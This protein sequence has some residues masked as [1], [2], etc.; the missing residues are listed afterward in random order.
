MRTRKSR[1]RIAQFRSQQDVSR[2]KKLGPESLEPRLLLFASTIHQNLTADALGF[3]Q[4]EV[5]ADIN[6]EH[7]QQD[8]LGQFNQAN[9]FDGSHFSDAANNI[10]AWYMEALRYADPD[11]FRQE[12]AADSFGKVLHAVQDFYSHSNW[13]ELQEAGR[14][15]RGTLIDTGSGYFSNLAPYSIHHGAMIVQGEDETPFGPSSSLSLDGFVV[16]VDT[17][18]GVYPG[19]ISG[20][21]LLPDQTPDNVTVPHGGLASLGIDGLPLAKDD[22]DALLF[23]PAKE[24]AV[25]QT[26]H[27]LFRL[28][29]LVESEYGSSQHLISSWIAPD[30][31]SDFNEFVAL[32]ASHSVGMEQLR[33]QIDTGLISGV[34]VVTHG[35]QFSDTG[36]DSLMPLAQAVLQRADGG[37]L[38]DYDILEEGAQPIVQIENLSSGPGNEVVVL[39]DWAPESNETSAG[40]GEAAGDALFANLIELGLLDLSNAATSHLPLHFV[41]HSFGTAVTSEA[42]ERLARF[43][44]EVD[45]VTLLDPHEFNQFILPVDGAQSLF[46]LGQ[47]QGYGATIWENVEFADVYYQTKTPPDGRPIPGAYN[48]YLPNDSFTDCLLPHSC[49]WQSDY[50]DSIRATGISDR[51]GYSRVAGGQPTRPE[52][53]FF[54]APP[55]QSHQHSEPTIVHRKTGEP[56]FEDLA[57]LGFGDELTARDNLTN[58]RWEPQWNSLSVINGDFQDAGVFHDGT[59]DP[60]SDIVPGWSHHGGGGRG[61]IGKD[62]ENFFLQLDPGNSRRMHNA[63]F[64]PPY[65]STLSFDL[66]RKERSSNNNVLEIRLGDDSIGTFPLGL[67]VGNGFVSTSVEIPSHLRNVNSLTFEIV[68]NGRIVDSEVRIDN[69]RLERGGNTGDVIEVNLRDIVPGGEEYALVPDAFHIVQP[70]GEIAVSW[71]PNPLRGDLL[72]YVGNENNVIGEVVFSDRADS[73][74]LPFS[75]S[76]RFYLAPGTD[77]QLPGD[78]D[79]DSRGWQGDLKVKFEV[80]GQ[81]FSTILSIIDGISQGGP[82]AVDPADNSVLNVMRLQQRLGYLGFPDRNGER[83]KVD[84][85]IGDETQHA[86][87]LFNGAVGTD[88]LSASDHLSDAGIQFINS[89]EAPTWSELPRQN[90]NYTV[91]T[92][93]RYGTSWLTETV[94]LA[95]EAFMR[96]SGQQVQIHRTSG[97]SGGSPDDLHD[98]FGGMGIDLIVT[99][100]EINQRIQLVREF[101]DYARGG[102]SLT[103]IALADDAQAAAIGAEFPD[104]DTVVDSR[105]AMDGRA[106]MHLQYTPPYPGQ[107]G[108]LDKGEQE[109]LREGVLRAGQ[110]LAHM[111]TTAGFAKPLPLVGETGTLPASA[112]ADAQI[113]IGQSLDLSNLMQNQ[114]ADSM[115]DVLS[116]GQSVDTVASLLQEEL[117]RLGPSTVRGTSNSQELRF[118]VA[119]D[120]AESAIQRDLTLGT[121]ARGLG[122]QIIDEVSERIPTVDIQPTLRFEFSFGLDRDSDVRD[123]FFFEVHALN[124][125]VATIPENDEQEFAERE[126]DLK[127][128][129]V[130]FDARIRFKMSAS[131]ELSESITLHQLERGEF[132]FATDS[133]F[134]ANADLAVRFGDFERRFEDALSI[135]DANLFDNG[136]SAANLS[137]ESLTAGLSALGSLTR[138]GFVGILQQFGGFF[139]RLGTSQ[140]FSAPLPFTNDGNV[141]NVVAP[142]NAWQSKVIDLLAQD[143]TS[144]SLQKLMEKA[145]EAGIVRNYRL[146]D[147]GQFT[148]DVNFT[149]DFDAQP[150][151]ILLD[152]ELFRDL[153]IESTSTLDVSGTLGTQLT[154]GID[155]S[156][157]G[158]GFELIETM[159]LDLLNGG[160]GIKRLDTPAA[161]F[162]VNFRDGTEL[163]IDVDH[164][165]DAGPPTVAEFRDYINGLSP[166]KLMLRIAGDHFELVDTSGGDAVFTIT[167][168]GMGTGERIS[169]AAWPGVGLGI[170]GTAETPNSRGEYVILGSALHGDSLGNRFYIATDV[171]TSPNILVSVSAISNDID[172]QAEYKKA[173]EVEI[174]N[175]A[176]S[177]GATLNIPLIDPD[178]EPQTERKLT[179]SELLQGLNDPAVHIVEPPTLGLAAS[180][181][182]PIKGSLLNVTIPGTARVDYSWQDTFQLTGRLN[183]PNPLELRE[184]RRSIAERELGPLAWLSDSSGIN[185]GGLANGVTQLFS[186]ES[187]RTA[188]PGIKRKLGDLLN[189]EGI[190][191]KLQESLA[192]AS[193]KAIQKVASV[194]EEEIEN[195]LCED[196]RPECTV[197][198]QGSVTD[199]QSDE[200]ALKFEVILR[201]EFLEQRVPLNLDL[202]ELGHG[203]LFAAGGTGAIDIE[204]GYDL[205]LDFGF[206][207]RDF[208]PFLYNSS[209]ITASMRVDSNDLAFQTSIGPLG[210]F[211]GQ[212]EPGGLKGTVQLGALKN[213]PRSL[214]SSN[215]RVTINDT[216]GDNRYFLGDEL[217]FSVDADGF[218]DI[219]LPIFFPTVSENQLDLN[220]R[221]EDL[222]DLTDITFSPS[223]E[224]FEMWFNDVLGDLG[225]LADNFRAIVTGWDGVFQILTDALDG[226]VFG[227]TIPFIGDKLQANSFIRELRRSVGDEFADVPPGTLT[228]AAVRNVL[229]NTLGKSEQGEGASLLQELDGVPGIT[230]QDIWIY[231]DGMRI[232]DVADDPIVVPQG[233]EE[234]W[235]EMSLGTTTSIVDSTFDFDIGLGDNFGLSL[236]NDLTV[237]ADFQIERFGIGV[238]RNGVFLKQPRDEDKQPLPIELS[239]TVDASL[240]NAT[241]DGRF[242]PF[243]IDGETFDQNLDLPCVE[244]DPFRKTCLHATFEVELDDG[245]D[246]TF[247]FDE[248]A[249]ITQFIEADVSGEAV[250][251]LNLELSIGGDESLP[252]LSSA[253]HFDWAFANE[254]TTGDNSFGEMPNVEF[255]NVTLDFG[256]F[257]RRF[258]GPI[259]T[260]VD[261]FLSPLDPIIDVLETPLPIIS[262]LGGSDVTPLELAQLLADEDDDGFIN[263]AIRVIEIVVG[264]RELV[265]RL[266]GFGDDVEISF[267][268]YP[269]IGDLRHESIAETTSNHEANPDVFIPADEKAEIDN[270]VCVGPGETQDEQFCFSFPILEKRSQV[271]S[272]LTGGFQ[273]S[274]IDLFLLDMPEL[275]L[276]FDLSKPPFGFLSPPFPV[277]PPFLFAYI[278]GA[279]SVAADF[280]FG[281]DTRGIVAFLENGNVGDIF[282]DGFYLLDRPKGGPDKPELQFGGTVNVTIE[283]PR[284]PDFFSFGGLSF[285]AGVGGGLFATIDLDLNDPN[286]DD[287]VYLDEL[288]DN[289]DRGFECVFDVHGDLSAQLFAFLNVK[290]KLWRKSVTLMDWRKEFV[291]ETLIDFNHSC[292]QEDSVP[293]ENNVLADQS[294]NTLTLRL[295]GESGDRFDI[296][297]R[298]DDIF[299]TAGGTTSDPYS[300][301]TKIVW[302]AGGGNDVLVVDRTVRSSVTIEVHGGS[303]DDRMVAYGGHARFYGDAGTDTLVGGPYD[304]ELHGGSEDDLLQGNGGVDVLYGEAGDDDLQGGSGDDR[305][306]GGIG[307]DRLLGGSGADSLYGED[308][309]DWLDGGD[310][311]DVLGRARD[312]GE[313]DDDIVLDGGPGNDTI[314][315]NEGNDVQIIG[316]PGEDQIDG[317]RGDDWIYGN[318]GNDRLDGGAGRDHVYGGPGEDIIHGGTGQ[319]DLFG[320]EDADFI[321]AGVSIDGGDLDVLNKI[322]GGDGRDTIYGDSGRDEVDGGQGDDE[323]FGLGGDDT[324]AGGDGNDV[325]FGGDGGDKITGGW[326]AD[327]IYAGTDAT[328]DGHVNEIHTIHGDVED[329]TT[330]VP[331]GNHDDF[332]R[333]A[334]GQDII[335]GFAG[336]DRIFAGE[337]GTAAAEQYIDAGEGNNQVSS[338]SGVDRILAGFGNDI[339]NAGGGA[340]RI[341]IAGG[342]NVIDAGDGIDIVRT[343]LG[344]D[345]I[346]VQNGDNDIR[347]TGGNN[348]VIT[349]NGSDIIRT[350][351]GVDRVES[352]AGDDDID[353]GGG[354]DT[355]YSGIGSDRIVGGWG[356]DL[357]VSGYSQAGGGPTTDTNTIFGDAESTTDLPPLSRQEDHAD[358]IY[359]DEGIDRVFAGF[360][361]DRIET[362]AGHDIVSA[363]NGNDHLIGGDGNDLLI[364]G[365]GDDRLFG[366]SGADIL[367]GGVPESAVHLLPVGV[368]WSSDATSDFSWLEEFEHLT[369]PFGFEDAELKASEFFGPRAWERSTHQNVT[370]T[371]LKVSFTIDGKNTSGDVVGDGRDRMFG[372]SDND[373]LFGGGDADLLEGGTGHDYLDGGAA[374]DTLRGDD[375]DDV[376]RGGKNNDVLRGGIGIDQ[377]YG[378]EGDDLLFADAG[379]SGIQVGQRLWGGAG[380]DTLYAYAAYEDEDSDDLGDLDSLLPPHVGDHL[381]GQAGEDLLFGNF[382]S[383]LLEGGGESDYLHGDYLGGPLYAR[384]TDAGISGL[385]DILFGGGGQDQLFGGGGAD[386]LH[387]EEDGD[388]LEGMDGADILVGGPGIDLLA[389]DVDSRYQQL[390]GDS[391]HGHWATYNTS[392][393]RWEDTSVAGDLWDDILVLQGDAT[394]DTNGQ[395]LFDDDISVIESDVGGAL[396]VSYDS[397]ASRDET[398]QLINSISRS[399][400]L[401]TWSPTVEQIQLAGLTGDDHLSVVLTKDT[402]ERLE[403]K[404]DQLHDV[405]TTKWVTTIGGGSGD[406]VLYGTAGRDRMDGGPGSDKLYGNAG[407]DRLWG[408]YFNGDPQRDFDEL[409]AGQGN[410]D[411]IGGSG[412][413]VLSAWS[414]EPAARGQFGIFVDST[415]GLH[416]DDDGGVYE[417]E[418]TGLNRM[419]G[420]AGPQ[421]DHLYGGTGLDFLYGNGGGGVNGDVLYTRTGQRFEE[422]GNNPFGDETDSTDAWKAYARQTDAVW[423]IGDVLDKQ[424]GKVN[425]EGELLAGFSDA[426]EIAEVHFITDPNSRTGGRHRVTIEQDGFVTDVYQWDGLSPLSANNQDLIEPIDLFIDAEGIALTLDPAT[427]RLVRRS[428]SQMRS[429]WNVTETQIVGTVLP[430]EG[431]FD[432]IL[433][434]TLGGNDFVRV[435][436]TVQKTV[437]V[438]AGDGDDVVRIDPRLAFLPDK[439]DSISHRNDI[440]QDVAARPAEDGVRV[441]GNATLSGLTIDSPT[442]VDWYR[443]SLD[444]LPER[445]DTF[446][447]RRITRKADEANLE[448]YIYDERILADPDTP[449]IGNGNVAAEIEL[450]TGAFNIGDSYFI[451]VESENGVTTDYEL[452]WT[453][454]SIPDELESG[455][456]PNTSE[457][458]PY[459]IAANEYDSHLQN[460]TLPSPER[461]AQGDWFQLPAGVTHGQITLHSLSPSANVTLELMLNSGTVEAAVTVPADSETGSEILAFTGLP[462]APHLLRVRADRIARYGLTLD[463]S[464]ALAGVGSQDEPWLMGDIHQFRSYSNDVQLGTAPDGGSE[465][466][467]WFTFFL[468][469]PAKLGTGIG[470][471]SLLVSDTDDST[472]NLFDIQLYDHTGSRMLVEE[473]T[474]SQDPLVILDLNGLAPGTYRVRVAGHW[475]WDESQQ[476][477]VPQYSN[478]AAFELFSATAHSGK[479]SIDFRPG[480]LTNLGAPVEERR[481]VVL[482]GNGD[483]R[484]LGGSGEDWIF[485]GEG[486]DILSGGYD[487]QAEDLIIG[488]DGDDIFFLTPDFLANNEDVGNSDIFVG[489]TGFDQVYYVGGHE[490]DGGDDQPVGVRDFVALGFDRFLGRHKITSLIWNTEEGSEGFLQTDQGFAQQYAFFRANEVERT[491]VDTRGGD[492]IVHADSGYVLN[493]ETWGISAGDLAAGASAFSQ[494]SILGGDGIDVLL[495]GAG[496]EVIVGESGD[497]ADASTNY[498]AG[499]GG[500]DVLLGGE[501]R[502]WIYGGRL[503]LDDVNLDA[504]MIATNALSGTPDDPSAVGSSQGKLTQFDFVATIYNEDAQVRLEYTFQ[505]FQGNS[506]I[507]LPGDVSETVTLENSFVLESVSSLDQLARLD[508][509]GDLNADGLE[510]YLVA[511]SSG[512]SYILFGPVTESSLTRVE[513]FLWDGDRKNGIRI[514]GSTWSLERRFDRLTDW[515]ALSPFVRVEGRSEVIVSPSIG[516]AAGSGQIL[517]S[518]NLQNPEASDL[519]LIRDVGAQLE[520]NIVAG[521]QTLPRILENRSRTILI[522]KDGFASSVDDIQIQILDWTGDDSGGDGLDEIIVL[523]QPKAP[524]AGEAVDAERVVGYV[525]DGRTLT[526]A[527]VDLSQ[528]DALLTIT[529]DTTNRDIALKQLISPSWTAAKTSSRV[530]GAAAGDINRDGFED[531]IVGDA[532]YAVRDSGT[533]TDAI[534][535]V[536][537]I[538]GRPR[539]AV[540]ETQAIL[541]GGPSSVG[542]TEPYAGLAN[543]VW[544]G[545]GLGS[546]VATVGD[547][548]RDGYD[549]IAF[550]REFELTT[551]GSVFIIGGD[552]RFDH[553]PTASN[554]VSFPDPNDNSEQS[555]HH[556]LARIDRGVNDIVNLD[557]TAGDFDGNGLVDIVVANANDNDVRIYYDIADR[558]PEARLPIRTYEAHDGQILGESENDGFGRLSMTPSLDLN[559]DGISD[560]VVGA[561]YADVGTARMNPDVDAGKV[562]IIFGSGRSLQLPDTR[563]ESTL[564][565]RQIPGGGLF[566]VERPDGQPF[567]LQH[568]ELTSFDTFHLFRVPIDTA[569]EQLLDAGEVSTALRNA[570]AN[571]DKPLPVAPTVF[572]IRP[573][574]E[575]QIVA[576]KNR[577]IVVKEDQ[578]VDVYDSKVEQWFTFT[579]LGD[580]QIGDVIKL[581]TVTESTE[582]ISRPENRRTYSTSR[583]AVLDS[584]PQNDSVAIE[585][586][587]LPLQIAEHRDGTG[588]LSSPEANVWLLG[589]SSTNSQLILE[590]DLSRLLDFVESPHLLESAQIILPYSHP[591]P[592]GGTVQVELLDS[593]GDGVAKADDVVAPAER[594]RHSP[595]Q[596]STQPKLAGE[597]SGTITLDVTREVQDALAAGRTRFT[598]RVS[599]DVATPLRISEDDIRIDVQTGRRTGVVAELFDSDG[600]RLAGGPTA[601]SII[602]LRNLRAGQYH[603]RVFD[604]LV[605]PSNVLYDPS[606]VPAKERDDLGSVCTDLVID[607]GPLSFLVEI[608]APKVGDADPVSDRDDI[609]GA[610]GDDFLEGGP[611]YDRLFGERNSE[612]GDRF[613]GESVEVRDQD[614]GA[615][616]GIVCTDPPNLPGECIDSNITGDEGYLVARPDDFVVQIGDTHLQSAIALELGLAVQGPDQLFRPIR[617]LLATDMTRLVQ[618]DADRTSLSQLARNDHMLTSIDGVEYAINLEYVSFA[619]Q[620]IQNL[621]QVEPGIRL[622]R[623]DQGELGL[624]SLR[625]VDLD[626]NPLTNG[627]NQAHPPQLVGPLDAISRLANLE[628][629]SI[630]RLTGDVQGF[631]LYGFEFAEELRNLRWLSA[632]ANQITDDLSLRMSFTEVQNGDVLDQSG[633]GNHGSIIG[634][635]IVNEAPPHVSQ[636]RSLK[637]NG[638]NSYVEV[639]NSP[640]LNVDGDVTISVWSKVDSFS[641]EWMPL[642]YKGNPGSERTYSI[643]IRNTGEVFL[644]TSD[645]KLNEHVSTPANSVSPNEWHHIAGS[646]DRTSGEMRIYL[647]G[648]LE[649]TKQ[650]RIQEAAASREPL[651]IGT[652]NES[653]AGNADY[654]GNVSDLQIYRAV[655][656]SFEIGQVMAG[657]AL[658]SGLSPLAS[659]A[660]L[661]VLNADTN[662]LEFVSPITSLN[663]L[664]WLELQ[665]NRLGEIV[666]LIGQDIVDDRD[667]GYSEIGAGWTADAHPD[668]FG[669]DYRILP[670]WEQ[671]SKAVFDFSDLPPGT[672]EIFATWPEHASRTDRASY[673]F[674]ENDQT[675]EVNQ[676]FAPDGHQFAG[677]SWQSVGLVEST[678]SG[679]TVELTNLGNGNLAADSVRVVSSVLPSLQMANL[680]RN[681]LDNI[682]H[683]LVLPALRQP[684][685][686]GPIR[687]NGRDSAES[688]IAYLFDGNDYV[689]VRD[690]T[691]LQMHDQVTIEAWIYPTGPGNGAGIILNKEGEYEIFRSSDGHIYWVIANQSHGWFAGVNT[692][693]VA[694]ENQWT[695]IAFTYDGEVAKTYANGD[696]VDSR[697]A[698]GLIGDQYP[699]QNELRIGGRQRGGDFF[700]GYIDDVQVW[701]V[702]RTQ[703]EIRSSLPIQLSNED[704]QPDQLVGF[705]NFDIPRGATILD[706]SVHSNHGSLGLSP[707]ENPNPIQLVV[708]NGYRAISDHPDTAV[709]EGVLVT[710]NL[711]RPELNTIDIETFNNS[712]FLVTTFDSNALGHSVFVPPTPDEEPAPT[713]RDVI[714]RTDGPEEAPIEISN[715]DDDDETFYGTKFTQAVVNGVA[716]LYV[717]GDLTI[718][719]GLITVI[720]SR[721]LSVVVADDVFITSG[722]TINASAV[723]FAPGPGGGNGG[724]GSGVGGQ[725]QPGGTSGS[726]G[727]GGAQNRSGEPGSAGENSPLGNNGTSGALGAIGFNSATANGSTGGQGG[728]TTTGGGSGGSAG[729]DGID[730]ETGANGNPGLGGRNLASGVDISGGDGGGQGGGGA[731]GRGGGGGGGGGGGDGGAFGGGRGGQGGL[732]GQGGDGGNGGIGGAGGG[733]FEIVAA[734]QLTIVGN[735]STKLEAKGENGGNGGLGLEGSD[736]TL[737]EPGIQPPG[738]VRV[739]VSNGTHGYYNN[740]IGVVFKPP[741]NAPNQCPFPSG[742]NDRTDC[743][744]ITNEPNL[745]PAADIL[746]PWL[747]N[748]PVFNSHWQTPRQIPQMWDFNTD[749]AIVYEVDGG[750]SGISDVRGNFGVDNGIFVWVNGQYKFGAVQQGPASPS[751]YPNI[752][753]GD[754]RPGINYI[755]VLREDHGFATDFY[756]DITFP[757]NPADGRGADGADGGSGG[758]G[759]GGANGGGGAGG[760]VKLFGSVV[761]VGE[762]IIDTSG[763][764]GGEAGGARTISLGRQY[765]LA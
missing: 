564:E 596:L 603:L 394:I 436:Q 714:I 91:E 610:G 348:I 384:N 8:T 113:T 364:G 612:N 715:D 464:R 414:R 323:I 172:A 675:V 27:E 132:E 342:N 373:W 683:E 370:P 325:I 10:N 580:G 42:I 392:A 420:S 62:G 70:N 136:E 363:G 626:R 692:N 467:K 489:G 191:T 638:Q 111:E 196:N 571:T 461:V 379:T 242:G 153:A 417:L 561:P 641:G 129:F 618:L 262:H 11:D 629:V 664:E 126:F 155:L 295:N 505:S 92:D 213:D 745:G 647:D 308:G 256:D 416:D 451:K 372:G 258:A 245:D 659:L 520:V 432:A 483:D 158:R 339:V 229:F 575:W 200:R 209:S 656:T 299:V 255:R 442:D 322:L 723:G 485:G 652:S 378:D 660:E 341:E 49:V 634:G 214:E 356:A 281:F 655:L 441:A 752:P 438:D 128:G 179:I 365:N 183:E 577:Y 555:L 600:R 218:L 613:K 292:S 307:A 99:G 643:W 563:N 267:G 466:E 20:S 122:L 574:I 636:G 744:I 597:T 152:T 125:S 576:G 234:I 742:N 548:N 321:I 586:Y 273:K 522:D 497:T 276:D 543:H 40:W 377:L 269:V 606:Y 398:G 74:G 679:L 640:I 143:S 644:S 265:D 565:N 569:D 48:A 615:P 678:A 397:G 156:P 51:Y 291:N 760:T 468:E 722:L 280:D 604:P 699:D 573:T 309:D 731:A 18:F 154:L 246:G 748:P 762:T 349:G 93:E 708:T 263:Q 700:Q 424:G 592:G 264:I 706:R 559:N 121:S 165:W 277:L 376:L 189:L 149:H 527:T 674:G 31:V 332:I 151:G 566:L 100:T 747:N 393:S 22:P 55:L 581:K 215:V 508:S 287:K 227:V 697:Q 551:D 1:R 84:G 405:N 344:N 317:G 337:G 13:V 434:D 536:Y 587:L 29:D 5:I 164:L 557:L 206:R 682:A 76:G 248:L 494:L 633:H 21:V 220:L 361:S 95:A 521:S 408:D 493:R 552:L 730:G 336:S 37:W 350:A 294:G 671:S 463:V 187:L 709:V 176:A 585:P 331:L 145:K 72:L 170:T 496:S 133:D 553:A 316:G 314:L 635:E 406:D 672:Y 526:D 385:P 135:G 690:S 355:V 137:P 567:R 474:T 487:R 518:E 751:E 439:T 369:T 25:A 241:L 759:G 228:V 510:D 590:L 366:D 625:F 402:V 498:I 387:G 140:L 562:Y 691:S 81:S 452:S 147:E 499:G 399:F 53:L 47:P 202:A 230:E 383:D 530:V 549:D 524:E 545:F 718:A 418:D 540:D 515:E 293:V 41:G 107:P 208:A 180:V 67:A 60:F 437:W 162:I 514:K 368:I 54:G 388:W 648:V 44:V 617:P 116:R 17:G 668:A 568:P 222:G 657:R 161:D 194:L 431:D 591:Q 602:D 458:S 271:F 685:L 329:L 266:D 124:A 43:D 354:D 217:D 185:L 511:G 351:D 357:I 479:Q 221:I 120:V 52:P 225:E 327:T 115:S 127:L 24:L 359:G 523:T 729:Q 529:T 224:G 423:Y 257:L 650:I 240:S 289:L 688:N 749:N 737:G 698:A 94:L 56:N 345:L 90:A 347:T 204:A 465:A 360:G 286:R 371:V 472:E 541:S 689:R 720:G 300:G 301:I 197:Q 184:D 386:Q 244:R 415:G 105:L 680:E 507:N 426:E 96:S 440:V 533:F 665:H 428:P 284:I 26:Q 98:H 247:A 632:S 249:R 719:P 754:F 303:G 298:G 30:G 16:E 703:T 486:D 4:Q 46:S 471:R 103:G 594:F 500:D 318:D 243:K 694:P 328:D 85:L 285:S 470:L 401:I 547:V 73:S 712:R 237:N 716:T 353:V 186:A 232:G 658:R 34:T 538:P 531:L 608:E 546:S 595:S 449:A 589:D 270:A 77:S 611:Y 740:D 174:K 753:L 427:G 58:V 118:D 326:G 80:D 104:I 382:R 738:W 642:V 238:N 491:V 717:S 435:G 735:V 239:F 320:D 182:L 310:R 268:D 138:E 199:T 544:Q 389:L 210:L 492:D 669:E 741:T 75:Q 86:I 584:L 476:V 554:G 139:G 68:G 570:F 69:V 396:K 627:M 504:D 501:D 211:V 101:R 651:F 23:E 319:D 66:W 578:M 3:L 395:P 190:Q 201:D 457:L 207:L 628:Y 148:F 283:P 614:Y 495:G 763:G 79:T 233:T 9:H 82:T 358:Q 312:V 305:L 251:N 236:E 252:S 231:A 446:S 407:D 480:D 160:E 198:V 123:G 639:E 33:E 28:F 403:T 624:K 64:I 409:Y 390:G 57:S 195:A 727:T 666:S 726:G 169:P 175:G 560:L 725:G 110:S 750:L 764:T 254:H 478:D 150:F 274:P 381:L 663:K 131:L 532:S 203:T 311:R 334:I 598:F 88:T 517:A 733:A 732:G 32:E 601:A 477:F 421:G 456:E 279:F 558:G 39:F 144:T 167:S 380:N 343:G 109:S 758:S 459:R 429:E 646:I 352:G 516:R 447:I 509:V 288:G 413:N 681:P 260:K 12:E 226:E 272:L 425:G 166:T 250:A 78:H 761:S 513:N 6:D 306:Y 433:L 525:F 503:P 61:I 630:D 481:D 588:L 736:G 537:V 654:A 315:G 696:L 620:R 637:L 444:A 707:S 622:D 362:F 687:G 460:L 119:L 572:V 645:T 621:G 296:A 117:G 582:A 411:L 253:F 488:G 662:H 673:R 87:G 157:L 412:G 528:A 177:L 743:G 756:I 410:D 35:Y 89:L 450:G 7:V 593:E 171:A 550:T 724:S 114:I 535:R 374:D 512:Q 757:G 188:I 212:P 71:R 216:D 539:S 192:K 519:V 297:A 506:G 755:Q 391:L 605:E 97:K 142:A 50:I 14:I 695:H 134:N 534:G 599:S 304:D 367:W 455:S 141:N 579:F 609:R 38:V 219:T 686:N 473:T 502:D 130:E 721:P 649:G 556:V 469:E 739:N 728:E 705:W 193:G 667:A 693:Y 181:S 15:P 290:A 542:E 333:G 282:A 278:N 631:E 63:I 375:G 205:Q 445:G 454:A 112:P 746:G 404:H 710:A 490:L 65:A 701:N 173:A 676:R 45:H 419:L 261:N 259:I 616:A 335:T 275:R 223:R 623:E 302:H 178:T 313:G 462:V 448:F 713:A 324:L 340:N 59:P 36:G 146:D 2:S 346:K 338:G 83:L 583:T 163:P 422:V 330:T 430:P 159:T 484:I 734:G 400:D 684:R 475:Q 168:G 711:H 702:A 453:F 482:G 653:L 443:F 102:I 670:S 704:V 108:V 677:Q 106:S 19:V 661:Q 235:F 607:C 619:G 765:S